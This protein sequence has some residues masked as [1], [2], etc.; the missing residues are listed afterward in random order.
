M[1]FSISIPDFSNSPGL[2]QQ[3]FKVGIWGL[4]AGLLLKSLACCDI[5][6]AIESNPSIPFRPYGTLSRPVTKLPIEQ[7]TMEGWRPSPWLAQVSE[8]NLSAQER[9]QQLLELERQQEIER[10]VQEELVDFTTSS[11]QS[12]VIV[13]GQPQNFPYV[14]VIPGD[15]FEL[16]REV[17]E[18]APTAFMTSS[19]RG[20]YIHTASFPKRRPA[21]AL[22][23]QLRHLGFD[24]QVTYI[25]TN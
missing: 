6:V 14:V 4:A 3:W 15:E 1:A 16:L 2:Q 7:G 19:R 13:L 12:D 17:Q 23:A 5:S 24:A 8:S 20:R 18:V 21:D 25:P 9:H 22:N 10:Q 11:D